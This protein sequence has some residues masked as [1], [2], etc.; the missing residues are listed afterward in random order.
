MCLEEIKFIRLNP[1]CGYSG[2][3]ISKEKWSLFMFLFLIF[4][5]VIP[6]VYSIRE[7]KEIFIISSKG[8][9]PW[10]NNFQYIVLY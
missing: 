6:Y 8:V 10:D 1:N 4:G 7:N 9:I 5:D 2:Y 3:E